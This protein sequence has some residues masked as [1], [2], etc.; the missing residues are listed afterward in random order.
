MSEP[1]TVER[2]PGL[3]VPVRN[4]LTDTVHLSF[5]SVRVPDLKLWA[6]GSVCG[7]GHGDEDHRVEVTCGRCLRIAV[8]RVCGGRAE[9][10]ERVSVARYV[11]A[12]H[13]SCTVCGE[14]QPGGPTRHVDTFGHLCPGGA[15]PDRFEYRVIGPGGTQC[16]M[17]DDRDGANRLAG[18]TGG[19]VQRRRIHDWEDDDA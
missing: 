2:V 3:L 11:C 13:R 14:R 18:S 1:A 9:Y 10:R 12:G 5:L 15:M 19:R 4:F 17:R 6:I 8:C 7:A 16:P